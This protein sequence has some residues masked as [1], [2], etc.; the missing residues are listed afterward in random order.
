MDKIYVKF[1]HKL[2]ENADHLSEYVNSLYAGGDYKEDDLN[3]IFGI[4]KRENLITC[5]YADNRAWIT[6]ITFTGKHYFDDEAK[7][8]ISVLIDQIEDIEKKFHFIGG[9]GIPEI[10]IIHDVQDFQDWIQEIR[11]ELQKIYDRT[12]DS[13]IG[14]TLNGSKKN[15]NGWNDRQLF[16]ELKGKLK[17]I[18]KNIDNYDISNGDV[19]KMCTKGENM[20]EKKKT[21]IFI[22]H[23]SKD[24]KYVAK[25]VD[26]LDGMGLDQSQIFCSSLPGYGIPID[27]NIFDYLREQFYQF[28]LHVIFIHSTNYYQSS[29][30]LNEMGAAWVLRNTVT[31][32][33]LPG[34][35]FEQM[36]GVVNNQSI[37]IKLGNDEME[38]KDKLNQLYGTVI[39]EFGLTK[40]AD[41]I[42][43]G[44]RDRFIKEIKEITAPD[45]DKQSESGDLEL[46][47]TGL[48]VKKSEIEAGKKI[49]YC[50]ACYQ[51]T[52]KLFTVVQGSLARDK[53]CSN[54]RMHYSVR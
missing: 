26:L 20:L 1:F 15:M 16:T 17:V 25:L 43:E 46:L 18:N 10:E 2:L 29:V 41:I 37:S 14:E 27:N 22:S 19:L 47:D 24:V 44:K 45:D 12:Q 31:S 34:F 40:K 48:L 52:G 50:H 4:L 28:N 36:T 30:S 54:C 5:Y 53:F 39:T 8:R 35:K 6:G 42:W 9:N 49:Y 7:S 11:F 32:F 3:Y 38:V 13:F 51:K 21:K 23:S 33:L